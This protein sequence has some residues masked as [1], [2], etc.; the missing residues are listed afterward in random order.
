M[1]RRGDIIRVFAEEENAGCDPVMLP[2][3]SSPRGLRLGMSRDEAARLLDASLRDDARRL[4]YTATKR[5]PM[6]REGREDYQRRFGQ[7][8]DE[9]AFFDSVRSVTLRLDQDRVYSFTLR[10]VTT[11]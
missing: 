2:V 7:F 3:V 1:L 4:F 10:K 9:D 8:S 6:T 5:I 11:F